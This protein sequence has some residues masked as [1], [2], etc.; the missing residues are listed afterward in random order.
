MNFKHMYIAVFL[1]LLLVYPAYTI[2]V[3]WR[4]AQRSAPLIRATPPYTREDAT[5]TRRILILGDSLAVGVGAPS[6]M[7]VA[8]R[9]APSFNAN[10][11]NYAK[12]GA[13]T[14][15]LDAQLSQAKN[16]R[17]DLILIQM[18]ANDIIQLRSLET[19]AG[20][21]DRA[22]TSAR[23]KS[24]RVAFLL[25]GN[26]GAAPLWPW[27]W[28]SIYTSRTLDLRKRYLAL[29]QKHDVLFVDIYTR[30]DIFASD[31]DRYYADDQLHLTADGY[32][33]WHEIISE[34]VRSRW[35]ELQ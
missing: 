15:D 30:D 19:A 25:V 3:F 14:K 18:G 4:A 13:Q 12:S 17:Y 32:E 31:P 33:T 29:A 26:V 22:I 5:L 16:N 20:N 23:Q 6:D 28:P 24:D 27:P 10:V 35:P 9:L 8:G 1:V 2:F 34:D 21:M 7:T 11:E